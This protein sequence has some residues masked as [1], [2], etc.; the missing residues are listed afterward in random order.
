MSISA[1]GSAPAAV[2]LRLAALRALF[3]AFLLLSLAGCWPGSYRAGLLRDEPPGEPLPPALAAPVKY[4]V[5]YDLLT[6]AN[7]DRSARTANTIMLREREDEYLRFL[8]AGY[9]Y[10]VVGC[11]GPEKATKAARI[12]GA[13]KAAGM[14]VPYL[15]FLDEPAL[16][17]LSLAQVNSAYDLYRSA[18]DS[19]G[20]RETK[21]APVLSLAGQ[22]EF[23]WQR[24]GLPKMDF[25][26][27][28]SWYSGASNQIHLVRHRLI[29]FLEMGDSQGL[30]DKEILHVIKVFSA[31]KPGLDLADLDPEW[32]LRQLRAATGS[33][34]S[35]YVWLHP[36]TGKLSWV[37]CEPLPEPY[38]RRTR[39]VAFY[40]M[41]G[42][43][44]DAQYVGANTPWLIQALEDWAR[45]RGLTLR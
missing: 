18:L 29:R 8:N 39:A 1:A 38:L 42:I 25:I 35:E 17:G 19:A 10:A 4:L 40:K 11:Y 3:L 30:G 6:P 21:I 12:V 5:W 37:R 13:A 28:D 44:S 34:R 36:R 22:G 9:R 31:K 43:A 32:V 41:D 23:S 14:E 16:G 7:L 27:H 20:H 24:W 2:P 15:L 45:P 33:G 26:A